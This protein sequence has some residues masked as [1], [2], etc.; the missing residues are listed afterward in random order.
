MF[1][2]RA[3]EAPRCLLGTLLGS[4]WDPDLGG[5]CQDMWVCGGEAGETPSWLRQ[6]FPLPMPGS[7]RQPSSPQP[8][9][10]C[11]ASVCCFGDSP[12]CNS[13]NQCRSHIGPAAPES[14]ET[15]FRV[16]YAFFLNHL[17]LTLSFFSSAQLFHPP[18]LP[19]CRGGAACV[20][21]P[22]SEMAND[23]AVRSEK[24]LRPGDARTKPRAAGGQ[25]QP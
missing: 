2:L 18:R 12:Q 20:H 1:P 13:S 4:S 6:S 25:A 14:P 19:E 8:S 23:I 22:R 21:L 5:P 24:I 9:R 3:P 16:A 11:R 17:L 15:G 10:S 7:P